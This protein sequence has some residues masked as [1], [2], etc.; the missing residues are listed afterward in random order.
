MQAHFPW[1]LP[2][3]IAIFRHSPGLAPPGASVLKGDY[4]GV[5]GICDVAAAR[6]TGLLLLQEQ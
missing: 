4:L 1:V 2:V 6:L 5:T 3:R